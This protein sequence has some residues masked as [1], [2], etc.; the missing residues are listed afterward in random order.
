VFKD[1]YVG[2]RDPGELT[3]G[4]SGVND[5]RMS[6]ENLGAGVGE[7]VCEFAEGT[8]VRDRFSCLLERKTDSGW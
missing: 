6:Y 3:G 4:E 5:Q 2:L 1:D 7:L 8:E